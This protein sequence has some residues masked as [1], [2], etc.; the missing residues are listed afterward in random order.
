MCVVA[1]ILDARRPMSSRWPMP[2]PLKGKSAV[3]WHALPPLCTL[4]LGDALSDGVG[5]VV[6]GH[7][8]PGGWDFP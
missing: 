7:P 5:A 6:A 8:S 2:S 4:G 1:H 3:L